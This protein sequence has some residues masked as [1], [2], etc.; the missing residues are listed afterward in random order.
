MA[1]QPVARSA[2][3]FHLPAY[4]RDLSAALIRPHYAANYYPDD[5][6]WKR[7]ALE[8]MLAPYDLSHGAGAAQSVEY[9]RPQSAALIDRKTVTPHMRFVDVAAVH[10]V[11]QQRK[12]DFNELLLQQGARGRPLSPNIDRVAPLPEQRLLAAIVAGDASVVFA[13]LD[14]QPK[15]LLKVYNEHTLLQAL[16]FCP[17]AAFRGAFID[18]YRDRLNNHRRYQVAGYR[19]VSPFLRHQLVGVGHEVPGGCGSVYSALYQ[20]GA[21]DEGWLGV[22]LAA[23]RSDSGVYGRASELVRRGAPLPEEASRL[24]RESA[25]GASKHVDELLDAV[26]A[27]GCVQV[28]VAKPLALAVGA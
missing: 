5:D 6:A 7:A 18:R 21:F 1:K 17:S 14:R 4:L 24:I 13:A 16:A 25:P 8:A 11:A 12:R 9:V 28:P 2:T 20:P 22:A 26:S 27:R 3:T 23:A 19:N 10:R 15:A